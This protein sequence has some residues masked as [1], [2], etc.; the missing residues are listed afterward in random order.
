MLEDLAPNVGDWQPKPKNRVLDLEE[1]GSN[2]PNKTININNLQ[3]FLPSNS[4]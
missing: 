1:G 4:I 2:S 3:A